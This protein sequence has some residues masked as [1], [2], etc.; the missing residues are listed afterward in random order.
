[1]PADLDEAQR[2]TVQDRQSPA[3][4]VVHEVIRQQGIEELERPTASFLWY[5]AD[6]ADLALARFAVAPGDRVARL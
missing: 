4:R 3:A 1:M 6:G 5:R 2:E